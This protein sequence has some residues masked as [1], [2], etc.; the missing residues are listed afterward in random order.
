M[1]R[2]G[3]GLFILLHLKIANGKGE[4]MERILSIACVT[5]AER[6]GKTMPVEK[7][8][9]WIKKTYRSNVT[10]NLD[11]KAS[12]PVQGATYECIS[13]NP[14]CIAGSRNRIFGSTHG[15]AK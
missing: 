2:G 8:L 10:A 6:A 12:Q 15:I 3:A 11:Q 9:A 7:F 13:I 14:P 4:A 1:S 5:P